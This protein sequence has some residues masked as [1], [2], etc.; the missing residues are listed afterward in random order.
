[1]THFLTNYHQHIVM[2][3]FPLSFASFNKADN[4]HQNACL[5]TY[6]REFTT[7]N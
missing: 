2:Y 3:C 7:D 6:F 4:V 1:M 5:L